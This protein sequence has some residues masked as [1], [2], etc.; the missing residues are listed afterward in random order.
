MWRGCGNVCRP[1]VTAPWLC[2]GVFRVSA[3]LTMSDVPASRSRLQCRICC[4]LLPSLGNLVNHK[5]TRHR[6]RPAGP[7]RRPF[8]TPDVD[9]S[10]CT[11]PSVG[12]GP[13]DDVPERLP[14]AGTG[15]GAV[16]VLPPAV[17]AGDRGGID[18]DGVR[19]LAALLEAAAELADAP[20]PPKRRHLGLSE[21]APAHPPAAVAP[22][23]E[24]STIVTQ[25]RAGFERFR[26]SEWVELMVRPRKRSRPGQFYSPRLRMLQD[27]LLGAGCGGLSGDDQNK[28]FAL[29]LF[30]E[31]TMPGAAGDDG[32]SVPL[33]ES[34]KTP[35]TLRQALSD[36]IDEAVVDCGWLACDIED[37]G[38][39]H[40]AYYRCGLK[41]SLQALR[42]GENVSLWS[43][44]DAPA[45]PTDRREDALDGEAFRESEAEVVHS[46]CASAFTMGIEM[47]SDSCVMSL[48][49]RKSSVPY[50]V[51]VR[52]G[53]LP[54]PP[55][56][57]TCFQSAHWSITL[58]WY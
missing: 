51:Q 25:A 35:H 7:A 24:Y 42:A 28:L 31:H 52:S 43:G 36:D 5:P 49:G 53:L 8:I 12:G 20:P 46:H 26:D 47:Y 11:A 19:D 4:R 37:G 9:E 38:V 1:S 55:V 23:V 18:I 50:C 30:C 27:V 57:K 58:F 39:Q 10:L 29:L 3:C 56:V 15:R 41:V 6:P 16:A 45:H 17:D 22:Q 14:V 13:A 34:L 54:P 21:G 48:S 33:R 32:H 44:G 40:R 2:Q